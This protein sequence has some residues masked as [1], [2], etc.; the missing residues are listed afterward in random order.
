M[1]Q[2]KVVLTMGRRGNEV[3][4]SGGGA[5]LSGGLRAHGSAG[6]CNYSA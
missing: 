6:R 2:L 1:R 4:F 5:T 3:G